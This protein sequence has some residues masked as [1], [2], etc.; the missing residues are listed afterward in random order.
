MAS[1]APGPKPAKQPRKVVPST[2]APPLSPA[3]ARVPTTGN[4]AIPGATVLPPL[5][6]WRQMPVAGRTP[7]GDGTHQTLPAPG[8]NEG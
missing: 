7:A 8:V 2:Q 5:T 4:A 3:T 1:K 6:P